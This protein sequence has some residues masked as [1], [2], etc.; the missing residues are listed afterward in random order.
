ME[1]P[2][3]PVPS[4]ASPSEEKR[5]SDAENPAPEELCAP[6]AQTC[7]SGP[8]ESG[9]DR[10]D[11]RGNSPKDDELSSEPVNLKRKWEET[12]DESCEAP[13]NL[14]MKV[15]V[16]TPAEPRNAVILMA[17]SFCDYKTIYPEVL[18]LHKKMVH[19]DKSDVPKKSGNVKGTRHTGCPPALNGKDV[20]PVPMFERRFPRRTKS[21]PPWPAKPQEK[22]PANAPP[23]PKPSRVVPPTP[24]VQEAQRYRPSADSRPSQEASRYTELMRKTS[25]GSKYVMDRVGIGDRSY[26]VRSGALWHS[27]AARLCLSSRFGSLP[28]MDFGEPAAKRLKFSLSI[29]REAEAVE[30]A[31]F[32]GPHADGSNRL[33]I[34]RTVQPTKQGSGPPMAPDVLGPAKNAPMAMGGSLESEWSMMNLLRSYP[35]HDLASLYHSSPVNPSHAGLANPGAGTRSACCFQ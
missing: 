8:P 21:P 23:A 10:A 19:K 33:F 17:C 34:K 15:S 3:R 28:Q 31:A 20:A 29:N 27:D 32:R 13:L 25:T 16:S 35:P 18:I 1:I 6:A 24:D 26:P 2:S 30:K 7:T 14:S 9:L 4:V 12:R 5:A 22:M 11:D